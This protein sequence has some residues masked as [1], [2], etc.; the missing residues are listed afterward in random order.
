MLAI[1]AT[2][3]I[4]FI[5]RVHFQSHTVNNFL[6]VELIFR[7]DGLYELLVS[8]TLNHPKI[9][10][11]SCSFKRRP[12]YADAHGMGRPYQ[13]KVLSKSGKMVIKAEKRA[14]KPRNWSSKPAKTSVKTGK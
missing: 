4:C 5:Q 7:R 3:S 14:S 13:D 10:D 12:H 1:D 2:T 8:Q 6:S 11:E 9:R